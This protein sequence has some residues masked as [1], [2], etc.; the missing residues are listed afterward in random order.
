M[1]ET[2]SIKC[3][4]SKRERNKFE[5]TRNAKAKEPE[6]MDDLMNLEK[7]LNIAETNEPLMFNECFV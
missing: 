3:P 4:I 1:R 6:K 5:E 7:K 2:K